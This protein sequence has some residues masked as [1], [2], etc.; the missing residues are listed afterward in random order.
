MGILGMG[1]QEIT[2]IVIV[3]VIIFGPEK[4][5]EMAGQA[6][7]MLRDFRRL[8]TD[9]QSEFQKQT[10]V[11]VTELKA[12]VDK[13]ISGLKSE[14]AGTTEAIEKQVGS[15]RSTVNKSASSVSKSV[16]SATGS[17][18]GS[19]SSAAKSTTKSATSATKSSSS[20]KG[21]GASASKASGTASKPA[22]PAPPP[23]ASKS[24]PLAD[25][26]F[27]DLGDSTNGGVAKAANGPQQTAASLVG[28]GSTSSDDL[29]ADRADALARARSRRRSAGYLNDGP[30]PN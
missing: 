22:A 6:G 8:T 26:S 16:S 25:V 4:L 18:S 7:R 12:S 13:E 29:P 15:V 2:I 1:W 17:K 3:A 23:R 24:D 19:K 30:S 20:T 9:M 28:A 14:M 10:G 27:L 21:S 11:S 5:P